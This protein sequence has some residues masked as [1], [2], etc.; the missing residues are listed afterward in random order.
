MCKKVLQ[1]KN[2]FQHFKALRSTIALEFL[3]RP[4]PMKLTAL[5]KIGEEWHHLRNISKLHVFILLGWRPHCFTNF[6]LFVFCWRKLLTITETTVNWTSR[7]WQFLTWR[8]DPLKNP[9]SFLHWPTVDFIERGWSGN[10]K[11]KSNCFKMPESNF[12]L[13]IPFYTL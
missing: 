1:K 4:C 11:A 13:I 2:G 5:W 12:F 8:H 6:C 10:F 3:L 9:D 7:I